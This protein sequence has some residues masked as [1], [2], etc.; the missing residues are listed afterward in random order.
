[1]GYAEH[2]S[3]SNIP[4]GIADTDRRAQPGVVTRLEDTVFFLSDL[5][6]DTDP[7]TRATFSQVIHAQP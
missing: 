4:F 3:L 5:D 7:V 2:F 1:M 6:L